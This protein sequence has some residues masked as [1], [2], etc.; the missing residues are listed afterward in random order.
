MCFCMAYL[1][2]REYQAEDLAKLEVSFNLDQR[3]KPVEQMVV[4]PILNHLLVL[5]GAYFR[6][7]SW[8]HRI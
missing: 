7:R 1:T 3:K 4:V 8:T 6:L 2:F 5:C